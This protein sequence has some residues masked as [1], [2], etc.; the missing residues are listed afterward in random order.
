M[1]GMA[2]HEMTRAYTEVKRRCDCLTGESIS[3]I[4]FSF[5]ACA[6][7]VTVAII[8]IIILSISTTTISSGQR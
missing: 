4:D 6:N 3:F 2:I 1:G 8:I 5:P 7:T